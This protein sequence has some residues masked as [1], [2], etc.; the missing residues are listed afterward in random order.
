VTADQLRA[1]A[2]EEHARGLTTW[3]E[4][5]QELLLIDR[6]TGTTESD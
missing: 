2:R 5:A 6:I 3:R 4:L 1:R